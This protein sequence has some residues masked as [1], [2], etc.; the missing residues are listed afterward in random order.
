MADQPKAKRLLQPGEAAPWFRARCGAEAAFNFDSM[1]GRWIVLMFFGAL[2]HPICKAG[3]DLILASRAIFDDKRAMFFGVTIDPADKLT[4]GAFNRPPGLRYFEDV[5]RSVSLLYGAALRND[6][7]RPYVILLDPCLRVV[8]SRPLKETADL[9][10][11]LVNVLHAARAAN[12]QP[13]G[14]DAPVLMVPRVFE[15]GFCLNSWPITTPSGARS[16]D[17]C[18]R[19]QV[20]QCVV[21]IQASSGGRTSTSRMR[22]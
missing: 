5:D 14:M 6:A 22:L 13:E 1:G 9:I 12:G 18:A 15:P 10:A 3:H 19:L 8:E 4:H 11:T 21:M 20:R 7:Y 17:S 2:S 16:R